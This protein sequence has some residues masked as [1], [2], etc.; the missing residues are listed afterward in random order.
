MNSCR[1]V[2]CKI[3]TRDKLAD[4]GKGVRLMWLE[5]RSLSKP[6]EINK[7]FLSK[8][9]IGSHHNSEFANSSET[10]SKQT[11]AD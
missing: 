10:Y 6:I 9:I 3:Q 1:L 11:L 4:T 7:C 5:Q 2:R 8:T